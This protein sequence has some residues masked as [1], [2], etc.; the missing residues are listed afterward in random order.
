MSMRQPH[1]IAHRGGRCWAPENTMAAFRKAIGVGVWG[2]ELDIHRCATGELVVIHDHDLDRTTDGV[3]L[4]KHTS[5]S[6][7]KRLS[8]G[9]WFDET[10]RHQ[11]VPCLTE[12][13][14]LVQGQVMLNIEIKNTPVE[15]HGIEDDLLKL[16][17]SYQHK[18]KLIISSFDHQ[19]LHTI[20]LKAP[21]LRLALLADAIFLNIADYARQVGCCVWHP[22]FDC[23]RKDALDEAQKAGLE[24]N[25]WTMNQSS[26]WLT[27]AQ[28]G[29]DGIVTDDPVGLM[30]F[31][32]TLSAVRS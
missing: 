30:A 27:G 5:Y 11:C 6:D 14:E 12:V 10:F 2:I 16:V 8:A 7:L 26:E 15:Y 31:L 24:V 19:L 28:M 23:L 21:D 32:E 1:V 4:V 18:D 29:L 13:L 3:G 25:A 17:D 22:A 9:L 20:H